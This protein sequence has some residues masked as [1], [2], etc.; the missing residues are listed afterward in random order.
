MYLHLFS[1]LLLWFDQGKKNTHRI[2]TFAYKW[3]PEFIFWFCNAM[4]RKRRS[5]KHVMCMASNIAR[6]YV[7][8]QM[9]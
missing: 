8:L 4:Q 9:K 6:D 1:L 7:R 2:V 5:H 3:I